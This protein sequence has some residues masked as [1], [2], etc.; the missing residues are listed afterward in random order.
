MDLTMDEEK[1]QKYNEVYR[2]GNGE[3]AGGLPPVEIVE[4]IQPK[5]EKGE[6]EQNGAI[7][8]AV[9]IHSNEWELKKEKRRN[10]SP[11]L[12]CKLIT[13]YPKTFFGK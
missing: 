3:K 5:L 12:Y 9:N 13:S 7:S 2:I 11:L 6:I 1:K 8:S 10:R 4:T